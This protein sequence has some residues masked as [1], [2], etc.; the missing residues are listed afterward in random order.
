MTRPLLTMALAASYLAAF[1]GVLVAFHGA[2][3][4]VGGALVFTG[5][6]SASPADEHALRWHTLLRDPWFLIW[7]LP[8]RPRASSSAA[9]R[10]DRAH[11]APAARQVQRCRGGSAYGSQACGRGDRAWWS[12]SWNGCLPRPCDG[13]LRP[14]LARLGGVVVAVSV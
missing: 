3:F 10:H 9:A 6:L 13:R 7:G 2:L 12:L 4:T 8:S 1:L 14:E 5:V 11:P